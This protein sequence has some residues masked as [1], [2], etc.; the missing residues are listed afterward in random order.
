MTE[1]QNESGTGTPKPE[2]TSA[3]NAGLPPD[4]PPPEDDAGTPGSAVP[5]PEAAPLAGSSSPADDA[6]AGDPVRTGATPDVA[7]G[8]PGTTEGDVAGAGATTSGGPGG[9]IGGGDASGAGASNGTDASATGGAGGSA[10]TSMVGKTLDSATDAGG[11]TVSNA[12]DERTGGYGGSMPVDG[13]SAGP[14]AG[15]ATGGTGASG[16]VTLPQPDGGDVAPPATDPASTGA[17]DAPLELPASAAGPTPDASAAPADA[18]ATGDTGSVAD[19]VPVTEA[20]PPADAPAADLGS[21]APETTSAGAPAPADAGTAGAGATETTG[22]GTPA[23]PGATPDAG[24]AVG[25]A[26]VDAGAVGG[27][28]RSERIELVGESGETMS[29][30]VRTPLGKHTVRQFGDDANVWDTEQLVIERAPDGGWQVVPEAG[31]TNE[32]LLNGAPITGPQPLRD[33][34]VI[35]VGRADKGIS[36]LPLTVR[37]A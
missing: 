3:E 10:D 22:A 21:V 16:D 1:H 11:P 28:L 8:G 14:D 26:E 30:G 29:V 37:G 34:D 25:G 24:S 9:S 36:R 20:P 18:S 2:E 5:A 33:G 27:P 6:G 7:S 13:S 23:T 35:A 31:T 4:A 17:P 15:A 12:A 32:T 19:A